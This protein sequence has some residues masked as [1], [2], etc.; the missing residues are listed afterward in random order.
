[1]NETRVSSETWH[2]RC[3][4]AHKWGSEGEGMWKGGSEGRQTGPDS[5]RQHPQVC[6]AQRARAAGALP[7]IQPQGTPTAGCLREVC[8]S[9]RTDQTQTRAKRP[10]CSLPNSLPACLRPSVP[11]SLD[12]SLYL[13]LDHG[14]CFSRARLAVGEDGGVVAAQR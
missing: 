4:R 12:C 10:L 6:L 8:T 14:V 2:L 5:A 1:M 13:I 3:R 11:C 7:P 9:K